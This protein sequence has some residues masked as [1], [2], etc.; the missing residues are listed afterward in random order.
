MSLARIFKT[1]LRA[2]AR[3]AAHLL[4][5]LA[6]GVSIG[7]AHAQSPSELVDYTV[8]SGDSLQSIAQRQF[9]FG[10]SWQ[11]LRELNQIAPR[12]QNSIYPGQSLKLRREWLEKPAPPPPPAPL[13]SQVTLQS[14]GPGLILRQ[15]G[16]TVAAQVGTQLAEGTLLQTGPTTG[17]SFTMEDGSKAQ[18][19]PNSSLELTRLQKNAATGQLQSVF[20]L[21]QGS[22]QMVVSKLKGAKPDRML[23]QVATATLGIR[24]TSFRVSTLGN[25]AQSEVLEGNVELG[26]ASALVALPGGYGSKVVGTAPPLPPIAL[27]PAPSAFTRMPWYSQHETAASLPARLEWQPV[28]GAVRYLVQVASDAAFDQLVAQQDSTQARAD[29]AAL[30]RGYNFV[31]VRAIDANGLAGYDLQ[32]AFRL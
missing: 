22:M 6:L 9:K 2:P 27:L 23:I 21:V 24:G 31:R 16:S 1:A 5:G 18:L 17:A 15:A 7:A 11:A 29:F 8:Q 13:P 4:L 12:T 3:Q 14:A 32:R 19:A 26:A 30:P 20:R 10:G 25:S 28:P